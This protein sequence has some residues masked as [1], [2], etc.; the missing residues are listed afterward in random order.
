VL[1]V[2][3]TIPEWWARR[4][5]SAG[6]PP[7]WTDWRRALSDPP[8]PCSG[9]PIIELID[10]SPTE[11]GDAYVRALDARMRLREGRHYTPDG[12]AETLWHD[13]AE[14]EPACGS[15]L[16]PACGAGAL[17]LPAIR[18]LVTSSQ[19]PALLLAT[20]VRRV[21]GT[22]TDPVAV[23]LGNALLAAELL[24]VWVRLPES[25][26]RPLPRL[27]KTA[28]GLAPA[29]DQPQIVV[30]N[31]PYGRVRLD[32]VART[33]WQKSLYGH[34][35]RYALFLHAAIERVAQNGLVAAVV[36]TSFLGGAY[37]QRLRTF[38][39]ERAPLLRVTFV[40]SRTGVFVGDVLQETCLAIFR[41]GGQPRDIECSRLSLNGTMQLDR[42]PSAPNPRNASRP[43]L[44]PRRSRDGGLLKAAARLEARLGHYGWKTTT[45][46]LVW[47]RHKQQISDSPRTGCIPILWAADIDHGVVRPDPARDGQRWILLRTRDDFMRLNEPAILVQRTTAP[48]QPRRLV[49]ASLDPTTLAEW[50]GSVVV[51]NHVNVLRCSDAHSPLTTELL[52]LMLKTP[53]FDRL[54]RCL[55]GTVAVSAY[56]LDAIP[57]PAAETL[58][59]WRTLASEQ[60]TDAVARCYDDEPA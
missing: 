13:I 43:W 48:E 28:D 56:E 54:Y 52:E 4:A 31:P 26:R 55:T 51:E 21:A 19:D 38:I 12:L 40:D 16:D 50:G 3:A 34:A 20:V 8:A 18:R 39:S 49:V 29:A 15:V 2:L 30:M 27:L 46:P 17:L 32:S 36:P 33:R 7:A 45:G 6:L 25:E 37:Y 42:L 10:A 23:W 22:D 44:L 24:P 9:T 47:N 14:F 59:A 57:L 1:D 53:T 58:L 41:K 35:N 60:L 11:V 5:F